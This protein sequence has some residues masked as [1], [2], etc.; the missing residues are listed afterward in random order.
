MNPITITKTNLAKSLMTGSLKQDSLRDV[1]ITGRQ[2][3]TSCPSTPSCFSSGKQIDDTQ[4]DGD[5]NGDQSYHR[6]CEYQTE[7]ECKEEGNAE[8]LQDEREEKREEDIENCGIG[9]HQV[10]DE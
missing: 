9:I 8:Y 6:R 4:D 10:L 3:C 2:T 5:D 1:V 7:Y